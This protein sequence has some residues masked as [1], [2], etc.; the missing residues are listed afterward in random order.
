M[1]VI[2][3]TFISQGKVFKHMFFHNGNMN[4][5]TNSPNLAKVMEI[6]EIPA[7]METITKWFQGD[8]NRLVKLTIVEWLVSPK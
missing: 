5:W 7:A 6:S 4:L 2:K 3:A 8:S 1:F